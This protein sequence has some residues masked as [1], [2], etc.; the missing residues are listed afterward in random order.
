MGQARQ[1]TEGDGQ[2]NEPHRLLASPSATK[3]VRALYEMILGLLPATSNRRRD[4]VTRDEIA[5][6]FAADLSRERKRRP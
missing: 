5:A 4:C 2:M 3:T 1:K 6:L